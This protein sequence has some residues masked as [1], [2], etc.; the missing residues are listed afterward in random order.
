[1]RTALTSLSFLIAAV[2][3]GA[4]YSLDVPKSA[5]NSCTVSSVINAGVGISD[6]KQRIPKQTAVAPSDSVLD[7]MLT[8]SSAVTQ[9][10]RDAIATAG[11]INISSGGTATSLKA[12][13]PAA[14]L[15]SY[16]AADTGRLTNVVIYIPACFTN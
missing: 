16:V 13:F 8:Y 1:M 6:F 15:A 11:G 9:A 4:C 12:Q 3:A 14:G 7:V 5:V 10:D 2:A